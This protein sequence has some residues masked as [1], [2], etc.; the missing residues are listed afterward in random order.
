MALQREGVDVWYQLVSTFDSISDDCSGF[1]VHPRFDNISDIVVIRR[2]FEA[3]DSESGGVDAE[4]D[5]SHQKFWRWLRTFKASNVM[6]VTL[7]NGQFGLRTVK[8]LY[9]VCE[10]S[11]TLEG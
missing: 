1:R 5:P 9:R 10:R 7:K 2:R 3:V 8:M 6:A 4:L 11:G